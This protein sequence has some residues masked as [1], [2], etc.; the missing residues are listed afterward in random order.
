[1]PLPEN[2]KL[3]EIFSSETLADRVRELAAQIDACYAELGVKEILLVCVLRGA[4]VF[5]ADLLREL[6][7]PLKLDFLQAS[8]YVGQQS[9]GSLV[10]SK[11]IDNVEGQHV[12][13][14][15]DIIDSGYTMQLL[16]A[17]LRERKPASLKL[18]ALLDK[19]EARRYPVPIDF[20]GFEV[21][22]KFLVG[23]GLDCDGNF[24]SLPYISELLLD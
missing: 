6:K 24:R 16:L 10:I 9:S 3:R 22:E 1:M 13:L 7:T 23:Y 12:L 11:D 5:Y 4:C 19:K 2:Y 18:C 14:V 8:S 21:P 15:E 17:R 20:T